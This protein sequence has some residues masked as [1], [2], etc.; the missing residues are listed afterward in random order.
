MGQDR[1]QGRHLGPG[2]AEEVCEPDK[3][4]DQ[5]GAEQQGQREV[6]AGP[7]GQMVRSLHRQPCPDAPQTASGNRKPA[8]GS[9]ASRLCLATSKRLAPAV[10]APIT[11]GSSA[12]Q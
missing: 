6:G 8:A 5:F 1:A 4:Q 2:H 11:S 9:V 12:G 7:G 10:T 3:E